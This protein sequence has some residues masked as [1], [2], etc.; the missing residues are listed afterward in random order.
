VIRQFPG[1][2]EIMGN[3]TENF[4]S[5]VYWHDP[6]GSQSQVPFGMIHRNYVAIP[7]FPSVI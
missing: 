7:Q 3:V 2:L 1:A 6:V 5:T 4:I